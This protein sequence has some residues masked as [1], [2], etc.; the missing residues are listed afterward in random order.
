[1]MFSGVWGVL[2]ILSVVVVVVG[3]AAVAEVVSGPEVAIPAVTSL[4]YVQK[5]HL[6]KTPECKSTDTIVHR[7]DPDIQVRK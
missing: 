2:V 7:Q 5:I 1:M 3:E 4:H 6:F